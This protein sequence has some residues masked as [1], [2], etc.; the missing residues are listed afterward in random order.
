MPTYTWK[1]PTCGLVREEVLSIRDYTSPDFRPPQHC[2]PME[3][4]YT[5]TNC[6]LLT[7]LVNDRHYEGMK[8]PD[9][10]DISSRAKHR[11]YMRANNLTTI[12][13]F[14]ET[15]KREA[16]AREARMAGEDASR[17]TDIVEAVHRLERGGV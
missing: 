12:D 2:A 8:A 15:W 6:P 14:T 16:L 17:T 13:D 3:R 1:C 10:T 4:F 5:A 9:G 11:E 7:A